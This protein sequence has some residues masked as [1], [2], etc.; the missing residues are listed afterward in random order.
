M[1]EV[2][3]LLTAF[4]QWFRAPYRVI[5]AA[6]IVL[7]LTLKSYIHSLIEAGFWFCTIFLVIAAIQWIGRPVL[8]WRYLQRLSP[9]ERNVVKSFLGSHVRTRALISSTATAEA[10]VKLGILEMRDPTLNRGRGAN[11]IFFTMHP[12]IF[13]YLEKRPHLYETDNAFMA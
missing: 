1:N 13:R 3:A 8:I 9:D 4:I 10:M 12:W 2:L 11:A 6:W 7:A 5:I